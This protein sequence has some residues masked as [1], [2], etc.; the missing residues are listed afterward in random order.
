MV[1]YTERTNRE[2][3]R[4]FDS[5]QHD[6]FTQYYRFKNMGGSFK[7]VADSLARLSERFIKL[8]SEKE[9]QYFYLQTVVQHVSTAVIAFT[10]DG[11]VELINRAAKKLLGI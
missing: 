1:R 10:A 5:V 3:S 8:R 7:E 9:E 4:F 11:K 2:L 6:D